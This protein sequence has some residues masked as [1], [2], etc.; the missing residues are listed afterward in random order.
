MCRSCSHAAD[1]LAALSCIPA[2]PA[3]LSSSRPLRA[4]PS[5]PPLHVPA[6]LSLPALPGSSMVEESKVSLRPSSSLCPAGAWSDT[7]AYTCPHACALLGD[8]CAF[9]MSAADRA[10]RATLPADD[11]LTIVPCSRAD[12]CAR[13]PSA[14]SHDG[15]DDVSAASTVSVCAP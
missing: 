13:L 7:H 5:Q 10:L 14:G 11:W 8:R 6:A 1:P 12:P 15:V 2:F 9:F 3:P 4:P